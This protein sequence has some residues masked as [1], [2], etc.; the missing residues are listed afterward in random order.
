MA[1]Q[2]SSIIS[3]FFASAVG[4]QN[5][6]SIAAANFNL[7]FTLVKLEAPEAFRG[8]SQSLTQKRRE[9]AE[10][11][12]LHRTAR[13]LGAL[14]SG[15]TPM[16]PDLLN[17]YG[18]RVSEI[19]EEAHKANT[20]NRVKRHL[21][22]DIF[23][24]DSASLWAAA[25]SGENA[26]A[27]HL[28][29][30]LIARMFDSIRAVSIWVELVEE[31]KRR[32]RTE[33]ANEP[34]KLKAMTMD[35]AAKQDISIRELGMW[36]N[37][38]RSWIQ[39][40]D[41][42]KI[43]EHKRALAS[44]DHAGMPVNMTSDTYE[45]AMQAWQDAMTS[46][47]SLVQGIP[48]KVRNGAVILAMTSWHLYPNLCVLS[49]G[50]EIIRQGDDQI[51]SSGI[52][53]VDVE[54]S[55]DGDVNGIVWSLPLS[56]LRHYGEPVQVTQRLSVSESRISMDDFR[57]VLLGCVYSTWGDF[58]Q[59]TEDANDLSC[60][61][62]EALRWPE[63]SDNQ[64]RSAMER[65]QKITSRTSWIG[66]LLA[67]A[68]E[69]EGTQDV[70]RVTARK[71]IDHGRR[72]GGFLGERRSHPAPLYDLSYIPT[73]F[74]VL[75]DD[76]ELQ[77]AFLRQYA[78]DLGLSSSNCVI[79]YV[80]ESGEYEFASVAPITGYAR[81]VGEH[82]LPVLRVDSQSDPL[83]GYLD[84]GSGAD[85]Q[86]SL[87]N[88]SKRAS[89]RFNNESHTYVRLE[90]CVGDSSNQR[91]AIIVKTGK[92][93]ANGADPRK[94]RP[95]GDLR[96]L[97]AY[98]QQ[99]ITIKKSIRPQDFNYTKL[100]EH[101]VT[102][103]RRKSATFIKF[104]RA[105][106]A[107]AELYSRLPDTT[108]DASV[109][110]STSLTRAR[111]IPQTEPSDAS[112]LRIALSRAQAFA[113]IAMFDAVRLVE[114]SYLEHVFAMTT[115]NSIFM[116]SPILADPY[117]VP[118]ETEITRVPGNIGQPG[119]S[120]LVPP[121]APRIRKVDR[122]DWAFLDHQ[123]YSGAAEQDSGFKKTSMHLRLTQHQP[124]LLSLDHD[125]NYIE[126][127]MALRE[128]L[129]QV[130]DGTK[131]VC[132]LDVLA[133]L[134]DGLLSRVACLHRHGAGPGSDC[135]G[136]GVRPRYRKVAVDNW[137]EL[138]TPPV[139]PAISV[140]RTPKDMSGTEKWMSRLAA[141]GVGV[142]LG[143]P[144]VIVPDSLCMECTENHIS[145]LLGTRPDTDIAKFVVVL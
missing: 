16:A 116:A 67:A 92:I 50:P 49:K 13:K 43:Q 124:A 3:K 134:R 128:T 143:R 66:Q 84:F 53:T 41:T 108:V 87:V 145:E 46:M 19:C 64:D 115:G 126:G 52:L 51:N 56:Y 127:G 71:L 125:E 9:D 79:Q 38:C 20:K 113:C 61:L 4:V 80:T 72:N 70:R 40:A 2:A 101:F 136:D 107:A 102:S 123:D 59:T 10:D 27:V 37:S 94:G 7:D 104:L 75:R 34:D 122:N 26:I 88:L 47:N 130:Y 138:F 17:A 117:E 30:C 31:R 81:K 44:T 63:R 86:T 25:T 78:K 135:H 76:P 90:F 36:D 69:F 112:P 111:W 142:R 23:G 33:I 97:G 68:E 12:T 139:D 83:N 29:A 140:V 57:Y 114:P 24:T 45:S 118:I 89:G 77:I 93:T 137:E 121:P 35:L 132:D 85:F 54:R 100:T 96:D 98:V 106:A 73:L 8:V 11:G 6:L 74:S 91:S 105:C 5:E 22:S 144:T 1:E 14:F 120:F 103:L 82:C 109:V 119:L 95:G 32:I 28:L 18:K 129:V 21:L 60:Y 141:V 110:A 99:G 39:T 48:Q 133:T 62:L 55:G 131:W 65:M 42:I 15:I 58:I